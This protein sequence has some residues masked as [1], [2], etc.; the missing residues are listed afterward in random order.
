MIKTTKNLTV[1]GVSRDLVLPSLEF[2]P[3]AFPLRYLLSV[4]R[5]NAIA[6][7]NVATCFH[8]F[9]QFNCLLSLFISAYTCFYCLRLCSYMFSLSPSVK[10]HVFIIAVFVATCFYCL[11]LCS[12]MLLLFPSM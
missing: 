5:E 12:Y 3:G 7:L 4:L 6:S 2:D 9:S 11:R 10:L 8:P 1:A